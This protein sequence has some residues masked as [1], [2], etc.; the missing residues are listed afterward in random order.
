MAIKSK[1]SE[2]WRCRILVFAALAAV[3]PACATKTV[4]IEPLSTARIPIDHSTLRP[5]ENTT[6]RIGSSDWKVVREAEPD[7]EGNVHLGDG[8]ELGL[9]VNRVLSAEALQTLAEVPELRRLNLVVDP[10]MPLE[11]W[12]ALG[13][14]ESIAWLDVKL[15]ENG[16]PSAMSDEH[17]KYLAAP[18]NLQVLKLWD[19][20]PAEETW[21]AIWKLKHL[22]SLSIY[23]IWS[24]IANNFFH[25]KKAFARPASLEMGRPHFS[26]D[27]LTLKLSGGD[28][29]LYT[30]QDIIALCGQDGVKSLELSGLPD[31][32]GD[33]IDAAL[34]WK[35]LERL[36]IWSMKNAMGPINASQSMPASLTE[37][38]IWNCDGFDAGTYFTLQQSKSIAILDLRSVPV[39]QASIAALATMTQLESL[40]LRSGK[41]VNQ[42]SLDVSRLLS[43]PKLKS[44]KLGKIGVA[45][46]ANGPEVN[47]LA[48]LAELS[49]ESCKI[50]G[51]LRWLPQFRGTLE[52]LELTRFDR[53]DDAT[54]E[55][56]L[57]LAKLKYL[58]LSDASE[59][60]VDGAKRLAAL[61]GLETLVLA[62]T[63]PE[64][65]LIKLQVLYPNIQV[66]D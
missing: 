56:I 28:L 30:D 29:A 10:M 43:M 13:A 49:F 23:E 4:A 12:A 14:N 37:L 66:D 7:A 32:R 51:D 45:Q 48:P 60:T 6:W 34:K 18:P 8:E 42:S 3:M 17:L 31:V 59:L 53:L 22:R 54:V 63:L 55:C 20:A 2:G 36:H 62:R 33:A 26:L 40:S 46:I 16:D 19:I 5:S 44:L 41:T 50:E 47:D 38:R 57:R 64:K 58:N 65:E 11:A 61:K 27:E 15:A 35:R 25:A 1:S 39:T 52:K 21:R 9:F 24:D